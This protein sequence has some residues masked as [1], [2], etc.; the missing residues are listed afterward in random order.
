MLLLL[1]FQACI[2]YT[3][4]HAIYA[5]KSSKY[6]FSDRSTDNSPSNRYCCEWG[7]SNCDANT[8]RQS[9]ID[10]VT[11][12]PD[13]LT[14]LTCSNFDLSALASVQFDATGHWTNTGS[15]FK[16][17]FDQ[18]QATADLEVGSI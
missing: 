11:T 1:M 3:S 6:L 4:C 10:I 15:T 5:F 13:I 14:N 17:V 2:S 12:S 8:G 9:P 18:D 16:Y 7:P